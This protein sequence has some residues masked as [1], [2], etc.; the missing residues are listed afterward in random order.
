MCV[1]VYVRSVEIKLR[2]LMIIVGG[3]Q[4]ATYGADIYELSEDT[5]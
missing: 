3:G 4:V 2:W 1:C 5:I